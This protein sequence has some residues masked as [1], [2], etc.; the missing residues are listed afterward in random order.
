MITNSPVA[1]KQY[2][3]DE[4]ARLTREVEPQAVTQLAADEG[5]DEH[6][7]SVRILEQAREHAVVEQRERLLLQMQRAYARLTA[8]AYGICEDCGKP[9]LVERLEALP[10]ATL[11]VACQGRREQ[12]KG[13]RW[14]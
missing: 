11:C 12:G 3:M 5:H 13:R 9:I 8:G 6:D 7:M 2:L 4:I 1:I 14:K 10:W